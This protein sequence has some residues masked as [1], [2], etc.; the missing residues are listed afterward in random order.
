MLSET[1]SDPGPSEDTPAEMEP[2]HS[3]VV[4][5]FPGAVRTKPRLTSN[6]FQDRHSTETPGFSIPFIKWH[7]GMVWTRCLGTSLRRLLNHLWGAQ[8]ITQSKR[9][10]RWSVVSSDSPN[11]TRMSNQRQSCSI[12][13]LQSMKPTGSVPAEKKGKHP[14]HQ[15]LKPA[16]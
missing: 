3:A 12:Y 11:E 4:A 1:Q 7:D 5:S 6:W 2:C 10:Q 13:F 16:H 15:G 8:S 14:K 9:V